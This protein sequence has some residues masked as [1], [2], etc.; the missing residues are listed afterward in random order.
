MVNGGLLSA[1]VLQHSA[2]ASDSVKEFYNKYCL[3]D[4]ERSIYLFCSSSVLY[5]LICHWTPVPWMSLWNFNYLQDTTL[6]H[7][8]SLVHAIGW[9]IVYFGCIMMDISELAGLKQVYYKLSGR[10]SPMALKSKELQRYLSNMRHPSFIGFL[11]ILWVYPLMRW[12][13]FNFLNIALIQK[14]SLLLL[15]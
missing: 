15:F 11:L 3:E 4:F 7:M 2:M 9:C 5:F 12:D 13:N 1:F 8:L 10:P 6:W 14:T